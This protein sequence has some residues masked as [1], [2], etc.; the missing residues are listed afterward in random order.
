[1]QV[2]RLS[3]QPGDVVVISADR[4]LTRDQANQIR[5]NLAG[6]LP[7]DVK[8]IILAGELAMTVLRQGDSTT[9]D[10]LTPVCLAVDHRATPAAPQ[11]PPTR[12]VRCP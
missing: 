4:F 11:P 1:M 6:L 2:A 9:A 7:A 3:L 10:H 5:G 8:T 12:S